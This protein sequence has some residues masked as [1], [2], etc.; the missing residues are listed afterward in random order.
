MFLMRAIE[1]IE[2]ERADFT[3]A[4]RPEVLFEGCCPV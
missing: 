3:V 1:K 2:V 4:N